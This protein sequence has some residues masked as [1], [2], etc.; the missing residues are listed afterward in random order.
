MRILNTG[1]MRTTFLT[2]DQLLARGVPATQ[3][4]PG[5]K[6]RQVARNVFVE[7]HVQITFEL[8]VDAFLHRAPIRAVVSRHSAA[9]LLGGIVPNSATIHFNAP[10]GTRWRPAGTTVHRRDGSP[11]IIHRQRPITPAETTFLELAADLELVDL[12][13]LGDS[14]LR[15]KHTSCERLVAAAAQAEGRNATRA[16]EAASLVRTRAESAKETKTRLLLF[17]A[18]LPEP[19][20]NYEILDEHGQL[21]FR[22]DLAYPELKIAIEYDGDYHFDSAEQRHKDRVRREWLMANGWQVITIVATDLWRRPQQILA[23]VEQALAAAG[24]RARVRGAAWQA[25]FPVS[26]SWAS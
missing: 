24:S 1:G 18:N 25:H 4:R 17:F 11:W 16:R 20:R 2:R 5:G 21:K 14:L 6:Y 19:E 15:K 3:L 22:L 8:R 13:V 9:V 10:P 7:P 26:T 23:R 12:V